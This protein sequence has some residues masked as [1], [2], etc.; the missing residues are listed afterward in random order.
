MSYEDEQ[1]VLEYLKAYPNVFVSANEIARKAA[2]RHR[3]NEEPHWAQA[4]LTSLVDKGVLERDEQ[5][6]YR[7]APKP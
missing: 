6:H 7:I 3:F 1:L 2:G 4:V 5:G